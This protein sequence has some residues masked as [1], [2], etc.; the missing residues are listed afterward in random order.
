MRLSH[1]A[2]TVVWPRDADGD[3]A[4]RALTPVLQCS[5]STFVRNAHVQVAVLSDGLAAL[6]IT[7]DPAWKD[8]FTVSPVTHLAHYAA[9]E[10]HKLVPPPLTRPGKVLLGGLGLVLR[11]LGFERAVYINS[12]LLSTNLYPHLTPDQLRS[13]TRALLA[14]FPDR[15]LVW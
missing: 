12:W 13:A 3:Y 14:A 7:Y 10:L 15:P 9:E 5:A 4:R 2:G 1:D 8:T 11:E 6:P